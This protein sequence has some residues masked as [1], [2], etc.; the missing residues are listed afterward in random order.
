MEPFTLAGKTVYLQAREVI[1]LDEFAWL[2]GRRLQAV[3]L[4]AHRGTL[5]VPVLQ[6][7]GPGTLRI[8]RAADALE[9]LRTRAALEELRLHGTVPL[10]TQSEGARP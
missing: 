1:T 7:R 8:L 6:P 10:S 4:Q 5:G 2:D 3:R 9:L